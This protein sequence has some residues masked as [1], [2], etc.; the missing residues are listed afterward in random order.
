MDVWNS[1]VIKKYEDEPPPPKT[2]TSA[3][4]IDN[5]MEKHKQ[6]KTDLV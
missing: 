1:D 2:L 3:D 5:E 6:N 4:F